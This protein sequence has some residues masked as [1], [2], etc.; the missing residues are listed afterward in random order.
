MTPFQEEED[1]VDIPRVTQ[2]RASDTQAFA[3]QGRITRSHA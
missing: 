2:D 1:V 3:L